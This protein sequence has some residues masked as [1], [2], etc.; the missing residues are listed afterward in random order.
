MG[1]A[2]DRILAELVEDSA[3]PVALGA[4]SER[5]VS[6]ASSYCSTADLFQ[7]GSLSKLV[8]ATGLSRLVARS[9]VS[10][11]DPVIRAVPELKLQEVSVARDVTYLHLLLHR[12]GWEGDFYDD[13]GV[14]DTALESYVRALAGVPQVAP[15]DYAFSYSNSGFGLLGHALSRHLKLAFEDAVDA[16]V[17]RPLGLRS[18]GYPAVGRQTS[19]LFRS[20]YPG[21]GFRTNMDD[22]LT[23]AR[24]HLV[25]APEWLSRPLTDAGQLAGQMAPGW[26][27]DSFTGT[28]VLRLGGTVAGEAGLLALVPRLGIAFAALGTDL[29]YLGVA[30]GRFLRVRL[31]LVQEHP[32]PCD[33]PPSPLVP[34]TGEFVTALDSY[35][36]YEDAGGLM[37]VRNPRGGYPR[38]HSP[39]GPSREPCRLDFL[40]DDVVRVGSGPDEGQRGDFVRDGSGRVAWFRWEGR[41]SRRRPS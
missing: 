41:L 16:L 19:E 39:G 7:V 1:E 14:G 35:T 9:E 30:L 15:L 23:L 32:G 11:Q 36:L 18:S 27:V 25:D 28:P 4:L 20:A 34:F 2:T 3:Q 38:S 33:L 31:G 26:M 8:C 24:H 29:G 40:G 6:T 22:L 13:F 10:L 12:G 37:M 5:G 21:G 17:C